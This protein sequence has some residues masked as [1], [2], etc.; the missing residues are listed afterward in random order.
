V[1]NSHAVEPVCTQF[2]V[3]E[4]QLPVAALTGVSL[5]GKRLTQQHLTGLV[6]C[7]VSTCP[8]VIISDPPQAP[9][10]AVSGISG[11]F[12]TIFMQMRMQVYLST[13][14]VPL[15]IVALAGIVCL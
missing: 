8:G 12:L 2:I 11:Q 15:Y 3:G 1:Q 6:G 5:W 4:V 10:R 9:S 13:N 14:H 7:M